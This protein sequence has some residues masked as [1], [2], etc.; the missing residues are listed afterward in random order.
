MLLLLEQS[1][2]SSIYKLKVLHGFSET[3]LI[4][5]FTNRTKPLSQELDAGWSVFDD[6]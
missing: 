5:E 2:N 1:L 6:N 3:K 4:G